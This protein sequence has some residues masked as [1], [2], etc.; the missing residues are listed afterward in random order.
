M[1]DHHEPICVRADGFLDM[2]LLRNPRMTLY[3]RDGPFFDEETG[4]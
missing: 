1:N 4:E 3:L 2:Q